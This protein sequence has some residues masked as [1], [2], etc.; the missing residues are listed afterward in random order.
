M[1]SGAV[2]LAVDGTTNASGTNLDLGAI[3][4]G[5]VMIGAQYSPPMPAPPA[6]STST[7]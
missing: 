7:T 5:S 6:T 1:G 2:T 3:G 4:V